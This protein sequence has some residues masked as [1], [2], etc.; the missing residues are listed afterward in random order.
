VEIAKKYVRLFRPTRAYNDYRIVRA[1]GIHGDVKVTAGEAGVVVITLSETGELVGYE[2][3]SWDIKEIKGL[4][5]KHRTDEE[6]WQA[7]EVY[8][9]QVGLP[10]DLTVRVLERDE[11][12]IDRFSL[13]PESNGHPVEAWMLKGENR[14]VGLWISRGQSHDHPRLRDATQ[15]KATNLWYSAAVLAFVLFVAV[16]VWFLSRRGR[17]DT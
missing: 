11:Q 14:I 17:I 9:R 15:G 12:F 6:S 1:D 10:A 16:L 3:Y 5:G 13:K 8:L 2:D 4:P 7:L